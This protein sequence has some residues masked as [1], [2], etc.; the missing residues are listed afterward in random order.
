VL[1]NLENLD[2]WPVARVAKSIAEAVPNLKNAGKHGKT[3]KEH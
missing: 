1:L 2:A 3:A